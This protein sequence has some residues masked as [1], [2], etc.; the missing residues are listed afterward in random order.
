MK[1]NETPNGFLRGVRIVDLADERADFC[2]KLLAD[3]GAQVIKVEKPGGC[4][5]REIGPFYG[6]G[7][8]TPR[9]LPF[10]Y[11]NT[12]KYGITLDLDHTEG[13]SIFVDLVRNSDVL[14]ETFPPG[15]LSKIGLGYQQ[16]NRVNSKLIFVS[17][18]AFGQ[19]GPRKNFK[20]CDLVAAAYGGQMYTNGSPDREP[21]KSFG[22]QSYISASLFAVTGILLALRN[23]RKT[24]KGDF[25]DISLQ[26]SVTATLEHV[27]VRY[28]AE[29][30]V[31]RRQG[32]LHWNG[33]FAI[34]PCRDGYMNVTLYQHWETLIEWMDSEGLAGDLKEEVWLDEDYRRHHREHIVAILKKW[35]ST[36]TVNELFETAQLM[37]FPWAPVQSPSEV[38]AWPQHRDRGF[39]IEKESAGTGVPLKYPGIPFKFSDVSDFPERSVPLPGEHNRQIYGRV[40]GMSEETLKRLR[41]CNTI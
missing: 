34:L 30:V 32:Q 1:P 29:Q 9:S 22:D 15:H 10:F 4:A 39:F 13:R 18:T 41:H 5:S 31:Y 19:N 14:V 36:H 26:E 6:G 25:I 7:D 35:A 24:G 16:L 2:T 3:L 8:T 40:L 28:F 27:M 33:E 20:S 11:N 38:I 37:R 17:V 23:R 12:N 21:L